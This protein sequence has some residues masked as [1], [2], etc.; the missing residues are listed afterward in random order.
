MELFLVS[1][2]H[3]DL[4]NFQIAI[5]KVLTNPWVDSGQKQKS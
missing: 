5:Q 1:N 4:P 3:D 2:I